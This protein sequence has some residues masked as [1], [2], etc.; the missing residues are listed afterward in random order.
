MLLT[1]TLTLILTLNPNPNVKPSPNPKPNP[2]PNTDPNPS[3]NPNPN[4][5][6]VYPHS[7]AD[8][9]RALPEFGT[10]LLDHRAMLRKANQVVTLLTQTVDRLSG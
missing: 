5:S 6:Q 4:P 2:N 9:L 10:I 1:L 3:A 7:A 8:F